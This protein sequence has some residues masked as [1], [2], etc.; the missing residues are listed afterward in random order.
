MSS[1]CDTGIVAE[2][3]GLLCEDELQKDNWCMV[4]THSLLAPYHQ[5]HV[6][7]TTVFTQEK[8]YCLSLLLLNRSCN[9]IYQFTPHSFTA[10]LNNPSV[11]AYMSKRLPRIYNLIIKQPGWAYRSC[12]KKSVCPALRPT[13][14]VYDMELFPSKVEKASFWCHSILCS[15]E[16]AMHIF[17]QQTRIRLEVMISGHRCK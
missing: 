7:W 3:R 14:Q 5:M 11:W 9:L 17:A 2:D 1:Y 10:L 15:F 6:Q 13:V 16:F 4:R 12:S 8:H